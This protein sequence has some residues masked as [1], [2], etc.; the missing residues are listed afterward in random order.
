MNFWTWEPGRTTE[1]RKLH[2]GIAFWVPTPRGLVDA[3]IQSNALLH[4]RGSIWAIKRVGRTRPHVGM[5]IGQWAYCDLERAW[6]CN[7]LQ[8]GCGDLCSWQATRYTACPRI[9]SN[10]TR[11]D[12]ERV[13]T[14]QGRPIT[15]LTG[16]KTC[17]HRHVCRITSQRLALLQSQVAASTRFL[18]SFCTVGDER[19][20]L[21]G[22]SKGP[23]KR[24]NQLKRRCEELKCRNNWISSYLWRNS[25]FY[26]P[27]IGV[28]RCD[29]LHG[30]TGIG[31]SVTPAANSHA[32][33]TTVILK[34]E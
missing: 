4:C 34:K 2:R 6:H 30:N 13:A 28:T 3:T 9:R 22:P 27:R 24:P 14:F 10:D 19:S 15:I 8:S 23:S 5:H 11:C 16:T 12:A 17:I 25:L 31:V 18:A 26:R 29:M 32:Q 20:P 33:G 7:R 1:R 21:W